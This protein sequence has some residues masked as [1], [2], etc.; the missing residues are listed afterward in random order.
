M[1]SDVSMWHDTA[2]AL[3]KKSYISPSN[4]LHMIMD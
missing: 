2:I 1:A 4:I 3:T